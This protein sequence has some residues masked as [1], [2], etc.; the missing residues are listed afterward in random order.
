MVVDELGT[1]KE[2]LVFCDEDVERLE[3]LR[4]RMDALE[5]ELRELD[6]LVDG[7][8]GVVVKGGSWRLG[9]DGLYSGDDEVE[10]AS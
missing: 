4:G 6:E 9:G 7:D 5:E 8:E 1:V 10:R 3:V 2:E